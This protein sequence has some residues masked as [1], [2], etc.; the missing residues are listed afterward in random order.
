M[1][2]SRIAPGLFFTPVA[3]SAAHADCKSDI[4]AILK[5]F[6]T[7]PTYSMVL[8][9]YASGSTM[10]MEATAILPDR[11]HVI[12]DGMDMILTLHGF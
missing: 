4:E 1:P 3:T 2:F 11:M 7:A 5:A 9:T 6:Q 12:G 10:K 8:E